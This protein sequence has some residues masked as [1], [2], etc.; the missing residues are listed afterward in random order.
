MNQIE[1]GRKANKVSE[2]DRGQKNAN[3]I[4]PCMT[5]YTLFAPICP[6]ILILILIKAKSAYAKYSDDASCPPIVEI[7]LYV[8]CE[9]I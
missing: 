3:N 7:V 2:S 5:S 9:A 4:S 6:C 1:N 8:V